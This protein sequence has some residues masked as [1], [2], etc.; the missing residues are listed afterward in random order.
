MAGTGEVVTG[1]FLCGLVLGIGVGVFI[2]ALLSYGR[3][4]DDDD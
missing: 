3:D 4:G 2:M 1:W